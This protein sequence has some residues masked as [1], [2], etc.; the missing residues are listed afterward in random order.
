MQLLLDCGAKIVKM[1]E[2]GAKKSQLFLRWSQIGRIFFQKETNAWSNKRKKAEIFG[3]KE[4][5]L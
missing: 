4:E 2:W 1:D 3:E 5:K